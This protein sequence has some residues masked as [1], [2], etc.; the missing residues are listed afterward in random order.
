MYGLMGLRLAL[1]GLRNGI[2]N[3]F[4]PRN[5]LLCICAWTGLVACRSTREEKNADQSQWSRLW[6]RGCDKEL[7]EEIVPEKTTSQYWLSTCT[8][9]RMEREPWINS[10]F[11]GFARTAGASESRSVKSTYQEPAHLGRIPLALQGHN[12]LGNASVYIS[13]RGTSTLYGVQNTSKCILHSPEVN[14]D[15]VMV[16]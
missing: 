2:Q 6:E 9:H 4:L 14:T 16:H 5:T 13:R 11:Q 12:A 15:N 7:E 10:S 1:L 8:P 3:G